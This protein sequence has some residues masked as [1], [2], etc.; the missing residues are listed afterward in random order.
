VSD[1]PLIDG[2][3]GSAQAV[4]LPPS[5]IPGAGAFISCVSCAAGRRLGPFRRS[6]SDNELK[7]ELERVEA[8]ARATKD[9]RSRR[10]L[11]ERAT[12]LNDELSRRRGPSTN[13]R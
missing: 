7:R 11:A 13:G 5:D 4:A 9:S 8:A 3:Q 12:H 1:V 2:W 10:S 6:L